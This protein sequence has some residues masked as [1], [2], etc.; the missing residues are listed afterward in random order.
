MTFVPETSSYGLTSIVVI[1]VNYGTP[2]LTIAGVHSVLER[3][4]GGRQVEVHVVDNASP[5]DS[6]ERLLAAHVE[7]GWGAR[8][9]LYPET[10]NHGFGRGNNVVL[11][12]LQARETP[13]D[14][15]FLLNPD[16][17]LENE[18][19]DLLAQALD[20][21]KQAGFAGAGISEPDG[22]MVTSAFRFPSMISEFSDSLSFGPVARMLKN[23]S[24]PLPPDHPAG[25]VDWVSGAALMGRFTALEQLQFFD[26]GFFLYFEEVDLM[27]RAHRAGWRTQYA[28]QARVIHSEGT[29]TGMASTR[30]QAA[31]LPRYHYE[32]WQYY[33]RKNH[34]VGGVWLAGLARLTGSAG[35]VVIC[36]L[37]RRKSAVPLR[38]FRDFWAYSLR[39][40]LGRPF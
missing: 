30:A 6:V 10:K 3:N 20:A 1:I 34:G 31:A 5:D 15:V 33:F 12:A 24:V 32:S 8:V 13:P 11:Q 36:R 28:P 22:T 18:A 35:S 39:P 38:F 26:P 16:A 2:D 25:P 17:R 4:H 40:M 23:W 37:R 7:Q 19:I 14:A 27:R 29:A 9:T 21:D